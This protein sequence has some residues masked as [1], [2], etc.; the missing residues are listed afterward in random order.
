M[1]ELSR[2]FNLDTL[3]TNLSLKSYIII[4][5]ATGNNIEDLFSSDNEGLT[6]IAVDGSEDFITPL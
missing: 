4:F 1:L 5:D 6:K 2:N 3:G